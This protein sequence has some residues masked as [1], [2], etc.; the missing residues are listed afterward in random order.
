M[1]S[2]PIACGTPVVASPVGGVPE[3]LDVEAPALLV[4]A[5]RPRRG[6]QRCKDAE[7]EPGPDAVHQYAR[8]F[9]WDEVVTAQCAL[10]ER[11]AAAETFAAELE[12]SA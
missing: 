5:R 2:K 4:E 6:P 3:I 10:Y 9:G 8:R 12:V 7:R 11:V 1:C